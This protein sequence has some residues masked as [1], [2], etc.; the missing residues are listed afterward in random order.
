M[1]AVA[2]SAASAAA[3]SKLTVPVTDE[4]QFVLINGKKV[5]KE[6]R[7]ALKTSIAELKEHHRV[8]PCLAL[9]LVGDNPESATYVRLK[10]KAAK[11]AGISTVD[12]ASVL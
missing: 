5:A 12:A 4:E 3:E 7:A 8:T 6:K 9:I 1:A 2:T 10:C 11:A